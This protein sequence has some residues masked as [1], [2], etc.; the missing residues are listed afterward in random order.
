MAL[1]F[2][3]VQAAITYNQ[4]HAMDVLPAIE[5]EIGR[6]PSPPGRGWWN[7]AAVECVG[8]L[9]DAAG[10]PVD[11]QFTSRV[12]LTLCERL[13]GYATDGLW[14]AAGVDER[15]HWAALCEITGY[16]LAENRHSL[17]ALRGVSLDAAFTRPLA[18]RPAY[19]DAFVWLD[20]FGNVRRFAGAT[21]A[22]QAA[23]SHTQ[24]NE[25]RTESSTIRPGRYKVRK[26]H[27][28]NDHP[29]LDVFNLDGTNLIPA[30][31]EHAR[32]MPET[33][34]SE[35]PTRNSQLNPHGSYTRGIMFHPGFDTLHEGGPFSSM[36]GQT[37]PLAEIQQLAA[38]ADFDYVLLDA[39]E[40][41]VRLG[42][43]PAR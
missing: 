23:A 31:L 20:T 33:T 16:L 7:V 39:V 13:R 4:V 8:K 26:T 9:Q 42:R 3:Q 18:S 19:D 27:D 22:Y 21:H 28:Y 30:W 29:A 40:A 38:A 5:R 37:A 41:L 32:K 43:L 12:R 25:A 35:L 34:V 10:L 15:T 14:P 11:G 17:L 24:A 2:A 36:G 6:E 1:S